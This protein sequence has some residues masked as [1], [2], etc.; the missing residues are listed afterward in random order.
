MS[1][2]FNP[3]VLISLSGTVVASFMVYYGWRDRHR[4]SAGIFVATQVLVA[5]MGMA[6]ALQL[7]STDVVN[8]LLGFRV[9]IVGTVVVPILLIVAVAPAS[10][11]HNK[12]GLIPLAVLSVVPLIT[13]YLVLVTA[14]PNAM[15]AGA[16]MAQRGQYRQLDLMP[17]GWFWVHS[18]YSYGLFLAS[19]VLLGDRITRLPAPYR[20]FPLLALASLLLVNLVHVGV[21]L[22]LMQGRSSDVVTSATVVGLSGAMWVAFRYNA[23]DLLPL[24]RAQV[25]QQLPLGVITLNAV[26]EVLD[27]NA[28][29]V[30]YLGV[31]LRKLVHR[32]AQQ[33]LASLPPLVAAL[34]RK[35]TPVELD[36]GDQPQPYEVTTIDIR[37]DQG[38]ISGKALV[39]RDLTPELEARARLRELA[40][41][42]PVCAWCG[43]ARTPGGS[44]QP[45]ATWLRHEGGVIVSHVICQSCREEYERDPKGAL[46]AAWQAPERNRRPHP[47]A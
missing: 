27:A 18:I 15:V 14:T 42:I 5:A 10:M 29:A 26:G 41:Y 16:T 20:T 8:A 25:L 19:L 38:Q 34:E 13:L 12:W 21:N 44:W 31:P 28:T 33:A 39:V 40:S 6:H 30:E 36:R 46:P 2:Q 37:S 23:F 17:G 11:R 22:G 4:P 9:S 24:A 32:P 45:L 47:P 7:S 1:W 35:T 3:L 43:Q